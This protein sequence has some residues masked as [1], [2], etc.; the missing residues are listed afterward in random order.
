MI[1]IYKKLKE[2]HDKIGKHIDPKYPDIGKMMFWVCSA[3]LIIPSCGILHSTYELIKMKIQENQHYQIQ[4]DRKE[5]FLEKELI[6]KYT[7]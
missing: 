7:K 5:N 1:Q 4:E 6:K 3:G 2:T